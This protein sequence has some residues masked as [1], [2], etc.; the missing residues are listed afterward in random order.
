MLPS[1]LNVCWVCGKPVSPEDSWP[2]EYGF[3][4]HENCLSIAERERKK[5]PLK[6]GGVAYFANR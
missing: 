5:P 1:S 6:A 3:F 4:A 2:D